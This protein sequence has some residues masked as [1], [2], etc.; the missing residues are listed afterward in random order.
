M[1]LTL[2]VQH[3]NLLFN[4][5]A[6]TPPITEPYGWRSTPNA[7]GWSTWRRIPRTICQPTRT[8]WSASRRYPV[9][10]PIGTDSTD[11]GSWRVCVR[12]GPSM[13]TI[14]T[15]SSWWSWWARTPVRIGRSRTM[16][17]KRWA[18]SREDSSTCCTLIQGT[19][20]T[21]EWIGNSIWVW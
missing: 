12:F 16:P 2:S 21:E 15:W 13:L 7:T 19:M 9:T 18:V 8:C 10:R 17:C 5:T 4:F 3:S 11:R 6:V 20:R 1:L 14:R